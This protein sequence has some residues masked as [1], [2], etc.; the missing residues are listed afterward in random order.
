M[1][2]RGRHNSEPKA[3]CRYTERANAV[4]KEV[5]KTLFRDITYIIQSATP[6]LLLKESFSAF[7]GTLSCLSFFHFFT[8][9]LLLRQL[10]YKL[11]LGKGQSNEAYFSILGRSHT[12][13]TPSPN[14][15]LPL[16]L[17][18]PSPQL[19][20]IG[21]CTAHPET[22][23]RRNKA[24]RDGIA[25]CIFCSFHSSVHAGTRLAC[26]PWREM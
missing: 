26:G 16:L 23:G 7:I 15:L 3:S 9:F 21:Q 13:R 8:I 22:P 11:N 25:E 2:P 18:V 24:V 17:L 6:Q 1:C 5:K 19:L 10:I 4:V 14:L 12:R 20:R